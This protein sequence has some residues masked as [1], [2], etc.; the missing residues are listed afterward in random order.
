MVKWAATFALANG[1]DL[2][3]GVASANL[4]W[5]GAP[6]ACLVNLAQRLEAIASANAKGRADP[7]VMVIHL[8]GNDLG[9]TPLHIMRGALEEAIGMVGRLFPCCR[10]IWSEILPRVTYTN[11]GDQGC[12]EVARKAMNRQARGLMGRCGGH[13]IAHPDIGWKKGELFRGDGV[14]LSDRGNV[15]FIADLSEG[16]S[17]F[18]LYPLVFKYPL[19]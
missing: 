10:I 9:N 14:H 19:Y 16:L 17:L 5:R 18:H 7:D 8:G 12:L 4:V 3:I 2:D 13:V 15:L 11:T 1:P 6:G